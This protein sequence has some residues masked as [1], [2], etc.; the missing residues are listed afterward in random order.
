MGVQPQVVGGK[1][2]NAW[3]LFDM[4]GNVAEWCGGFLGIRGDAPPPKTPWFIE[5]ARGGSYRDTGHTCTHWDRG[6][7]DPRL[8]RGSIGFRPAADLPE[9]R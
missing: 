4:Y 6:L 2:P 5:P 3:G 1:L 7:R 9:L 8:R